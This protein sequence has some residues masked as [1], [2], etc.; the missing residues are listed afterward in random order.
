V[1][2]KVQFTPRIMGFTVDGFFSVM[3]IVA[4]IS[5]ATLCP[6][7]ANSTVVSA[8]KIPMTLSAVLRWTVAGL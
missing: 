3:P 7:Y 8:L 2:K 4:W 1:I 6:P 5:S